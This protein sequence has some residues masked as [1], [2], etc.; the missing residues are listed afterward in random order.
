MIYRI[1]QEVLISVGISE[2]DMV[3]IMDLL[4]HEIRIF[5]EGSLVR[6][7]K[8]RIQSILEDVEGAE[9]EDIGFEETYLNDDGEQEFD[10]DIRE[11]SLVV[12]SALYEGAELEFDGYV[13]KMKYHKELDI[14]YYVVTEKGVSQVGRYWIVP[15]SRIRM[16]GKL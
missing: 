2:Y 15:S 13:V 7:H 1:G 14:Y 6:C 5:R 3:R 11:G 10:V 4:I 8:N 9:I 12:V 16:K